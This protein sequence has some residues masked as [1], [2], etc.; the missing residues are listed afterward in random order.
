MN[1]QIY[2]ITMIADGLVLNKHQA[3]CNH[4]ADSPAIKVQDQSYYAPHITV[5]S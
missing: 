3:I 5:T 4:H 2:V 1:R